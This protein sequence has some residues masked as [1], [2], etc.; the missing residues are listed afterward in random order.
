[1]APWSQMRGLGL[2]GMI[3]FHLDRNSMC[4]INCVCMSDL[5]VTRA[6]MAD[7]VTVVRALYIIK[8]DGWSVGDQARNALI[9]LVAEYDPAWLDAVRRGL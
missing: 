8:K 1:M 5:F 3:I 4:I 2:P 6:E 7:L 9:R